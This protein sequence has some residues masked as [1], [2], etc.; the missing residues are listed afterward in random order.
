MQ[1]KYTLTDC[2]VK[3]SP[4]FLWSRWMGALAFMICAPVVGVSNLSAQ[5]TNDN[6]AQAI[7]FSV[8]PLDQTCATVEVNT[9]NATAS[10]SSACNGSSD[11]DVWFS[12]ELPEGFTSVMYEM[13]NNSGSSDHMIEVVDGCGGT[14]VGCYDP[15]SGMLT[16]LTGGNTYYIRTY[17]YFSGSSNYTICL[18][19][20]PPPPSNDECADAITFPTIPSDFTC[21][22]VT[23]NTF[24]ATG[25]DI[26]TCNGNEDDDV[27]F[28]FVMPEGEPFVIYE[29]TT[30]FGN[31]DHMIEVLDAC[32]GAS[33]GCYDPESG[34]LPGL[35]G[36]NTYYI[37]TYTYGSG[38]FSQYT[39]CL[40]IP[41]E[42]PENDDCANAIA[43][44]VLPSDGSCA[45][46]SADTNGASGS[47]STTCNGEEDDDVWFTFTV[48]AGTS[49]VNY[50]ITNN[51]GNSDHMIQ[52]LDACSGNSLG[53]YDPESGVLSGLVGGQTY[54]LRTYTY[55]Q[56][57]FSNYTICLTAAP[58]APAND[59]C[60][61]AIA[62][63]AIPEDETCLTVVVN[64]SGAGGTLSNTCNGAE[65][66]DVWYTFTV[67]VGYS[68]I[69][70]ANTSISG[71]GDRMLQVLD[72]CDGTSLGCYD[73]E[74]GALTGLTGGNTYY[75]RVYTYG[76]GVFTEF[77]LCLRLPPTP[78]ANDNCAQAIAFPVI[79]EDGA[80]S[81][82]TVTTVGATPS[83][84]SNCN[85]NADDDVWYSFVMPANAPYVVYTITNLSGN[86]DH[87]IQVL[88]A[89]GGTSLGCYDPE[90]GILSGLEAGQTYLL[91][92]YT[93]SS[94]VTSNYTICLNVPPAPP[95]NDLCD[96]AVAFPIIQNNGECATVTANTN[97]ATGSAV[98]TSG[99][100]DDDVWFTFVM[101]ED[102]NFLLYEITGI[103]GAT[104]YGIEVLTA[105]DGANVLCR[106][107]TNGVL[108]GL[109]AGETYFIRTYTTGAGAF[110]EYTICLK[111]PPA[112]PANDDCENATA[113]SEIPL[114]GD[115]ASV[116]VNTNGAGPS[117]LASCS[118]TADDDVWY[119]FVVPEG[120]TTVSYGI[121]TVTGSA[122]HMV[123]LFDACNGNSL[124]CFD[125]ESGA[126]TGLTPGATYYLRTYIYGQGTFGE[127][128]LCLAVNPPPVANDEPCDAVELQVS[129]SCNFIT[130]SNSGATD[131]AGTNVPAPGCASY[132]G[133]DVW[134]VVTVP[135]NGHVIIDA[136]NYTMF[137]AGMAVYTGDDCDGALTLLECDD[138]DS[139]NGNMPMIDIDELE[140][141]SS[142]YI[143]F[144]EYGNDLV[145]TFGICVTSPC[146][147]PLGVNVTASANTVIATWD[148][149]GDDVTYNWELRT[150]GDAGSGDDGLVDSGTTDADV[151]T[152]SVSD[153]DFLSTY[154][155][156]ISSNCEADV[157]SAWSQA[158]EV[159]TEVL[160]GCTDEEACNYNP[161]AVADDGSCTF[162]PILMY[163]DADGDGHG[164]PNASEEICGDTTG[165]V[166]NSDDC[167]DDNADVWEVT[168]F[169]VTLNLPIN[170]IC[171]NASPLS[172]TGGTPANGVWSG[173]AVNNGQ[174]NPS[175]LAAQSYIITYTVE[176]DGVCYTTGSAT[177]MIV[178]DDCSGIDEDNIAAIRLFPSQVVDKITVVGLHLID[179]EIYDISGRHIKTTSLQHDAV[180]DAT[181]LSSGLYVV[182]VRSIE[183]S[184]TFK[185][186]KINR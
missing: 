93:Y 68:S 108:N 46:V 164:N 76:S 111:T 38:V 171:D 45:S 4:R 167:D 133:G 19:L 79:P 163:E 86:S 83:G 20:P 162:E 51:S 123:Q 22:T 149:V 118:G 91:R 59:L 173:T 57:Q 183:S 62:L 116:L 6:C 105:C 33:L 56:G 95:A 37:R 182:K 138:D 88:S 134:F 136:I 141:G 74:S 143:R 65:D 16:G 81:T 99:E 165:Y 181:D 152:V 129:G 126:F 9:E 117:S 24:G 98:A 35:T 121:N 177:D 144:W 145:G 155:F 14:S 26:P 154:Y 29:I 113:F 53:C 8:L 157:T 186:E 185:I 140:P 103:S 135:A 169:V 131:S 101:P 80:C 175:G 178:V 82:V 150:S 159:T 27:W 100:E 67:P 102:A 122:D 15:E 124:F 89:C 75:L 63:D 166:T 127:Y 70:Y 147:A 5:P 92:T 66:D 97:G 137:D 176:G 168:Q 160:A 7:A 60:A 18:R 42:A 12:F 50:E 31:A 36:G 55:G 172:L 72:A 179:A 78:P 112:P 47:A 161:E 13:E 125:P 170:T 28:T 73:P 142:L 77:E 32:N 34:T 156:Y 40:S 151:T 61:N 1:E 10:G 110:S 3:F 139:D 25:S 158:Y 132:Q 49:Y 64:T 109:T 58:P 184:A 107:G 90:N 41:G 130:A 94:D 48:P 2:T 44:P 21:A 52:V 153:L 43:F 39:I 119:T 106:T 85:G 115:C 148:S 84:G 17:T 71:A 146:S 128:N 54:Y 87:M 180:I 23:A 174:F 30:L 104:G 120:H 69:L 11:D 96:D 114:S